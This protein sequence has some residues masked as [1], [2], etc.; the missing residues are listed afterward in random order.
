MFAHFTGEMSEDLVLIVERN[1]KHGPRKDSGNRTFE[2]NRLIITH[3]VK[4]RAQNVPVNLMAGKEVFEAHA[5]NL[6]VS[7]GR[8]AYEEG[9]VKQAPPHRFGH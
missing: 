5:Q 7:A 6:L 2:F 8:R 1:T 9:N 3:R 4:C